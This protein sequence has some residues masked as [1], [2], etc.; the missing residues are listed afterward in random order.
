MASSVQSQ[1]DIQIRWKPEITTPH[2]ILRPIEKGDLDFYKSLFKNEVAMKYYSGGVRDIT[3]RFWGWINRWEIHPYSA[4]AIVDRISKEL[5]GH[6]VFGHGDWKRGLK[7]GWS[8]GAIVL[9]PNQHGKGLGT[10][11]MRA[12]VAYARA[13][14]ERSE[15]V[16]CDVTESQRAEVEEIAT[17]D[18]TFKVH[19][20][21]EGQID[22]VYLPLNE[23]Q[24]TA[25]HAN[26]A[27][28]KILKRI[29]SEE[30]GGT[31]KKESPLLKILHGQFC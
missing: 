9:H 8:E 13:L 29:F 28:H 6:V 4:L 17:S 31:V 7:K 23:I 26:V 25:S 16:P 12:A 22:W 19:R 5:I 1:N 30:N 11:A 14:K 20:N 2:L 15:G 10:E 3:P 27:G 21:E 24:A 18:P